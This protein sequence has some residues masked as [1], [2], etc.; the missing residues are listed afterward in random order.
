MQTLTYARFYRDKSII[1]SSLG[2][3]YMENGEVKKLCKTSD[4]YLCF[5]YRDKIKGKT[6][7]HLVHRAV[8]GSFQTSE[9]KEKVVNHLNGIKDDNR[10]TNLEYCTIADNNRHSRYVLHN[11][12]GPKLRNFSDESVLTMATLCSVIGL[13]ETSKAL[14]MKYQTLMAIAKGI[15]YRHMNSVFF[16]IEKLPV[17]VNL[18][19][20]TGKLNMTGFRGVKKAKSGKFY[21]QITVEKKTYKLPLRITP[22]EAYQD[23]S[24]AYLEWYGHRPL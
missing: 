6:V 10:L 19:R 18:N 1:I 20:K 17:K 13:A 2:E 15:N 9:L 24:E 11:S 7:T 16:H 22:E 14:K 21:G 3:V 12:S 5:S 23:Y 4:G 8:V